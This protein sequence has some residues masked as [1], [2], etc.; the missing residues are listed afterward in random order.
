[1]ETYYVTTPIYYVNDVP[2]IGHAYTTIAA[3]TL[4]RYYRL[5]GRKVY[6]L[7]GTDEHGQKMQRA[8]EEKGL[9]PQELADRNAQHF[10]D[11]WREMDITYDDF[12]RTTEKRHKKGV[13]E[14]Y[15]KL[16]ES[17]D[18]YMGEYED[19]YCVPDETYYT[20]LQLVDGKCPMCGRPVEK[21]KEKSLFFRMNKYQDRLI[22]HI[23]S[24]PE[25]IKPESRRNEIKSFIS[26]GLRDLSISRTTFDWG[27]PVPDSPGHVMY[28]W[29]DALTNY[30]S[31]LGFGRDDREKFDRFWPADVHLIGKDILRHHAVYWPCLLMSAGIELPR[32]ITA[33]GWWTVEGQKMSKS[34]GNFVDPREVIE[35]YGLDAFRYF[36]LRDVTFGLDGDF[37]YDS[38]VHR[39]NSDLA[40]DLGNLL[41]R[42]VGM[43]TKY[44]GG[45]LQGPEAKEA[46]DQDLIQTVENA[47][48]QLDLLMADCAFSKALAAIWV[49]IGKANK[50]IDDTKPFLLAKEPDK[51]NR[52]NSVLYNVAETLRITA[53]AISAFMP[54]ASKKMWEQLN[55]PG[56]PADPPYDEKTRWGG[57]KAGT[58]LQK[59]PS[60]F[61]RIEK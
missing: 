52:L 27:I 40:N 42:T 50:Y 1:M 60:L 38:M 36:L 41:A 23:D 34:L 54:E 19:W 21:M 35:K 5:A 7:T 17:G 31:A 4:A 47:A 58:T 22:E 46:V 18:V 2:H 32:K 57:L 26:S 24:H 43:A 25:F 29:V 14:F 59:G 49:M 9:H 39:I 28:V 45:K 11:L 33:H 44:Q 48:R 53:I 12:I 20:E 61:P 8:A 51:K 30:I 15:R 6:F 37:S 10:K 3:D 16:V 56:S 55:L 13:H